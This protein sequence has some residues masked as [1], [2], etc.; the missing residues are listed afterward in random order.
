[1]SMAIDREFIAEEI[2]QGT[3]LP[4]YSFV[5]PGIGNYG[6]PA[7]ADYKDLSPIDREEKAKALLKEAGYGPGL[8]PLKVEIRYNT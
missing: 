4:A 8:K 1:L 2:W 5:P 6:T 3:M 7:Y